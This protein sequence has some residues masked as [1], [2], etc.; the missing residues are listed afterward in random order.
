MIRWKVHRV[1]I[2]SHHS[3]AM[4]EMSDVDAQ[5]V[6]DIEDELKSACVQCTKSLPCVLPWTVS[7]CRKHE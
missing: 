1:I 6:P 3:S 2:A 4:Q 7:V 5:K